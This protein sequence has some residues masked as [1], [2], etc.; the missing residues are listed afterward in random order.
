V[1]QLGIFSSP[2]DGIAVSALCA[3][4][5]GGAVYKLTLSLKAPGFQTLNLQF[6]LLVSSICC[7]IQLVPLRQGPDLLMEIPSHQAGLYEL[8]HSLTAP[9]F[10]P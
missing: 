5:Q 10:N 1:D 3:G 4:H 9:G 6:D 7:Q 8:S 2:A